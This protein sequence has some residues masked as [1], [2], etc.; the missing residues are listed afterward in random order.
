M[1]SPASSATKES[2]APVVRVKVDTD[3]VFPMI[4]W[5]ENSSLNTAARAMYVLPSKL[6]TGG[7]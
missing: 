2:K 5:S 1:I 7:T 3:C 6:T 4:G